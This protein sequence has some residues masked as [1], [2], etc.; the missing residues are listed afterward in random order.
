MEQLVEGV[1]PVGARLSPHHEAGVHAERPAF[2]SHSLAVRL[3]LELLEVGR[4]ACQVG[5]V[6]HHAKRLGTQEARVPD[7][8]ETKQDRQ[9]LLERRG[10]EV[11]VHV[12]EASQ[13]L[14]EVLWSDEQHRRQTDG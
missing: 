12:V 11:D 4:E 2:A 6:G 3:H 7:P 10:G 14:G 8:K 5:R 13:H 1:L 9:V